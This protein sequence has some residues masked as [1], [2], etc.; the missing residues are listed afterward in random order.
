MPGWNW[1]NQ[2]EVYIDNVR[3]MQEVV[4]ADVLDLRLAKLILPASSTTVAQES[5]SVEVQNRG[6]VDIT[7]VTLTYKVDVGTPVEETFTLEN[8]LEPGI[9]TTLAFTEKADFSASG[10]HEVM[11]E[12]REVTANTTSQEDP[13]GNSMSGHVTRLS[14]HTLPYAYGFDDAED[15]A[16]QWKTKNYSSEGGGAE[17]WAWY[18]DKIDATI[19]LAPVDGKPGVVASRNAIAGGMGYR[20]ANYLIMAAPVTLPAGKTVALNFN[21]RRSHGTSALGNLL[22]YYNRTPEFGADQLGLDSVGRVEGPAG[23]DFEWHEAGL[24]FEVETDGEYYIVIKHEAAKTAQ[25]YF[26]LDNLEIKEGVFVGTPDIVVENVELPMPSCGL[27]MAEPISVRLKNDGTATVTKLMLTYTV[28]DGTPV[29]DTL[30]DALAPGAG[31]VFAF[32]QKADLSALGTHTVK[33]TAEVLE[34]D[35]KPESNTENNERSASVA[36]HEAETLPFAA[37]FTKNSEEREKMSYQPGT[38]VYN[39]PRQGMTTPVISPLQT[40]CL[41]FE[42]DAIYRFTLIYR[43]GSSNGI[44]TTRANFDLLYGLATEPMSEWD[45]LKSYQ[46]VYHPGYVSELVEITDV[47]VSGDYAVA[48]MPRQAQNGTFAEGMIYVQSVSVSRKPDYDVR[49]AA[50]RSSLAALTPVQH[51]AKPRFEVLAK[52]EGLRDARAVRIAIESAGARVALSDSMNI[53]GGDSALYV[54]EAELT[55]LTVGDV[56]LS[57]EAVLGGSAENS[58]ENKREWSFRATESDYAF[59]NVQLTGWPKS[60]GEWNG[61]VYGQL[62][63]LEAQDTL[64]AVTLG[65]AQGEE[66]FVTALHAM[67]EVWQVN[68]SGELA[69]CLLAYGTERSEEGGVKTVSIPARV[70]SAGRYL[71]GVRQVDAVGDMYLGLDQ[72]PEGAYYIANQGKVEPEEGYY[73]AVRAKFGKAPVVVKDI[74]MLSIRSPKSQGIFSANEPIEAG[75]RN[76]GM[77]AMEVTFK[78]TVAGQTQEKKVNV[79]G[80]ATGSVAFE[81]DLSQ[82]GTYGI[83]VE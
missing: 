74:E 11:V 38:W 40:P 10:R 47:E 60:V 49:I 3:I 44:D 20:T 12:I 2:E 82:A 36:K 69:D 9:K 16:E 80:Y 7:A 83:L 13:E 76:N 61:G 37:D 70:L 30:K 4:A 26:V 73:A 54:F 51:A 35:G 21:Y 25:T 31:T 23:G 1:D 79:A 64:T 43:A 32:T 50:I 6:S 48:L 56:T 41:P 46:D 68:A 15:F 39:A 77:A 58:E 27:G 65:W 14:P 59:D 52:N 75:W 8:P 5:I 81:A 53:A 63:D 22:V 19:D 17:D 55:N 42:A 45:T 67:L 71:I 28:N 24:E 34:S 29:T 33:V 78:C 57:L 66:S 62:F 72:N 18:A